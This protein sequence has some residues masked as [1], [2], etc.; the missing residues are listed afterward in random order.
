MIRLFSKYDLFRGLSPGPAARSGGLAPGVPQSRRRPALGPHPD[1]RVRRRARRRRRRRLAELIGA[2]LTVGLC[3]GAALALFVPGFVFGAGPAAVTSPE[4]AA[5]TGAPTAPGAPAG[6]DAPQSASTGSLLVT[7]PW[8]SGHGQ[9]G[10]AAPTEG[11]VRGPEALAVAPDGRVA[12]LDSVNR[13]VVLLDAG[14]A[15]LGC[16]PLPLTEPRFLAVSDDLL[17][18]LDC[19]A[20]RRLVALDWS[21]AG[22][23]EAELPELG[24]VV[25]GLFATDSGPCVEVAHESVFLIEP[26]EGS[27][28]ATEAG[29]ATAASA[30]TSPGTVT[31]TVAPGAAGKVAKADPG[32]P[33]DSRAPARAQLRSLPGR[34][35]GVALGQAAKVTF[36]P[37]RGPALELFEVDA[38]TLG[39]SKKAEMELV[40]APRHS[41]EH[42]VSV[43]DDGSGGMVVGARLLSTDPNAS[44]QPS[45][46]IGRFASGTGG[47]TAAGAA[48]VAARVVPPVLSDGAFLLA[49]SPFAYLGQPYAVAPDGRVYQ[50]VA[51]E[52]GYSIFVH[53]FT[54]PS[55]LDSQEVER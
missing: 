10:L 47:R 16:T 2:A 35:L 40:V 44:G 29:A 37:G 25:T 21:G 27:L 42:L 39:S 32:A 22:L 45:L 23:G 4:G 50:P 13:R 55:S 33:P 5:A 15:V 14:G 11:L 36:K 49:D 6:P 3:A 28:Q 9:I 52:S 31:T 19:D 7:L 43:D 12:I 1:S 30:V 8:G 34:P 20:D 38:K 51:D 53:S 26:G 41:V 48:R 24:D 17:Y 46:W 54:S 18:V